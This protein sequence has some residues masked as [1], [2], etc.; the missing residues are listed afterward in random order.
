MTKDEAYEKQ[1]KERIALERENKKLKAQIEGYNKG[2]YESA[3]KILNLK[4]ISKLTWLNAQLR[5][6]R[7]RYKSNWEN[8]VSV[9][10][11]FRVIAFD[12]E[13][14]RDEAMHGLDF[15]RDRCSTLETQLTVILGKSDAHNKDLTAQI[16]ALKDALLKEKAKANND[17]TNSGTP[18]S[19]TP[20]NKKKV[21]PNSR[22][23]SDKNKGAQPGHKKRF[24]AS[25]NDD[26]ITAYEDHTLD[27]C[28]DC[29]SDCL[30]LL[31]KRGKDV[32]DYE[33]IL[34]KKRHNFWIYQC[35]K[36]GHFVHSPIPLHLKEQVQYGPNI[37]A[38]GLALQDIGYV[39]INRTS[40]LIGGIIG[41]GIHLSEGYICKLQKRASK[42]LSSFVE[43]V[44]L[45]C[46][47]SKILH[48]DD[49]VIFISAQQACMRFYGNEKIA[50]YKA[51]KK[52]DRASI[53]DDAILGALGPEAT[54]IHD[55]VTM[56]YND[57]FHFR[58]AECVQHLNRDIQ[59]VIDISNHS[60]AVQMK[61]TI[62]DTIHERN[63]LVAAGVECFSSQKLYSF[64]QTIDSL[65]ALASTEHEESIGRY[66]ETDERKLISRIDK[67]KDSHFLW[68]KDFS[69][70]PTNNLAERS[71][72]SQKVKLKVSGQYQ[73]VES[74]EYFADIRTY[75]E[76]C[77]RNGVDQFIALTRLM[78]GTPYTVKELLSEA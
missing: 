73:S 12:A 51:H 38:L 67:Y 22:E 8:Q 56:N 23:K 28:P 70:A 16:D 52:K 74:A 68:A 57:D 64:L 21:I 62:S 61:E 19:Q 75:I 43:E 6:E 65:L 50:L 9:T 2:T 13:C 35:T 42:T 40:K 34:K 15:Y 54:V 55:H 24:I 18:T 59:K 69:V 32:I 78:S 39:S 71:L 76:T 46:I 10:E 17:G 58:N 45:E 1:R 36:C 27:Y 77:Y 31:G 53:D 4:Q 44:R 25:L 14:A 30:T 60:W 5:N 37:Q 3:D 48:W 11:N 63:D 47:K 29:G 72:R 66:Y 26:E 41:N 7:D 33:V 20:Y 49:T